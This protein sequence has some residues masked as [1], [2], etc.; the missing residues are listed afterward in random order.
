M[1]AIIA[2]VALAVLS[3]AE[4]IGARELELEKDELKFGFGIQARLLVSRDD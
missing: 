2:A 3:C 1:K 4:G